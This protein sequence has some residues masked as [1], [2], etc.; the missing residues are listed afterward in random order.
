METTTDITNEG[1]RQLAIRYKR[2]NLVNAV[3][4]VGVLLTWKRKGL[5]V[6]HNLRIN[7]LPVA[8]L[9]LG[10]CCEISWSKLT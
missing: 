10:A 1:L 4:T 5:D 9:N 3:K 2:E 8:F 7:Y 6:F